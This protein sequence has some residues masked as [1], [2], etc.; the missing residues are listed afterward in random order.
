MDMQQTQQIRRR[1]LVFGQ[2]QGVGFRPCIYKLATERHFT[3][4]VSN[5]SQG[6]CIEIQGKKAHVDDFLASW[7]Q[8]L[9]PLA[10]V[11]SVTV[12]EISCIEQESSFVILHSTATQDANS[13][14]SKVLISPDVGLCQLCEQ[15]M[16][17]VDNA[18]YAYPFTNC[19]NCGPR[20]TI[21]KRIP[22]DRATTS[23]H[24]FPLCPS[25][26]KEYDNP[27]DRRFHAQPNACPVCGPQ[28]W[29]VPAQNHMRNFPQNSETL[30]TAGK[31]CEHSMHTV[32]AY[33]D[34]NKMSYG[35][36]DTSKE[37]EGEGAVLGTLAWARQRKLTGQHAMEY[38][39]QALLAGYIVAMKG[40]GGFH[41]ACSALDV[42]AIALLRKRKQR[43]HKPLAVMV[44]DM[45]MAQRLA[46][47]SKEEALLL[48][49]PEKPIVLCRR[50]SALPN[51]L[52]PDTDN[53]GL[54]LPYTPLHKA[55]FMH[56]QRHVVGNAP[57]AL[58]M[59]SGNAGGE[60]IC[61]GNREALGRLA[62]LADVFL[63]HNRDILVR[64]DD[65]VC[66]VYAT[67]CTVK[68]AMAMEAGGQFQEHLTPHV[69]PDMEVH[70][71]GSTRRQMQPH[72]TLSTEKERENIAQ[73]RTAVFL[74]RA[75]G[76]VPR[77][78]TMYSQASWCARRFTSVLGM[79]AEL[80]NT[81]CLSRDNIAFVG[82]HIGDMHTLL[83]T[84]FQREVVAH[85]EMLLQ[86]R[87]QA[88]VHDKHPDF[89]STQAAKEYA[90]QYGIP[91][92][93]LQHHFAHAYA[94]L[95][96]HQYTGPCL[97]ITLDG[98][99]YGDDGTIWGGEVLYIETQPSQCS[100]SPV[101]KRLG[102]LSSFALMGGE[103]AIKE[104]W[105]IA[106]TLTHAM[107]KEQEQLSANKRVQEALYQSHTM[108]PMLWE[109]LEKNFPAPQTSSAGRLFD[110]VAAALG[111]CSHISYE[112]QA[113]ILLEQAQKYVGSVGVPPRKAG[114]HVEDLV[115][116]VGDLWEISSTA[117][118]QNA[119]Q[120]AQMA[121]VA[122]AAR[123][124][125]EQLAASFVYT[126]I[127]AAQAMDVRTVALGGGVMQNATLYALLHTGLRQAGLTVLCPKYMPS[128]DGAIAL[129][130]VYYGSLLVE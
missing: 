125:H 4:H 124:F 123:T 81:V 68:H 39:A 103:Q 80:K 82:Q 65:S 79:G 46:H 12:T 59:T 56:L 52:A 58:V 92:F 42:A 100:T 17:D 99:G 44:P 86:V 11:T 102:A 69:K 38:T 70:T 7:Q 29:C 62:L 49:S 91:C 107:S 10:E 106:L 119:M 120:Q 122:E 105:R 121:S 93:A 113:A 90:D 73:E 83:T 60:P 9:P 72:A 14:G 84:A 115:S 111:L 43:P 77:P 50:K 32:Q 95:A 74:R 66:A 33:V 88:V 98:T 109:M 26:Q 130:Q 15:D 53:I 85:L 31:G 45:R 126:T 87:P 116:K 64:N 34:D 54:V 104:P 18:R 47:I 21:T 75:R 13:S 41:L 5:T 101:H 63:L 30:D 28:V 25:C 118:F 76:Y 117:L 129:G 6:V 67:Y 51:I 61:L 48:N 27:L 71:K 22:Y 128:N 19:T 20:Y 40:L 94:V 57:L 96:E 114:I 127:Q 110:A 2:V 89:S 112:G 3:G 1:L 55:L 35:H 23:M 97:A 8:H 37:T 78:V 108:A 36:G 16:E 24:C